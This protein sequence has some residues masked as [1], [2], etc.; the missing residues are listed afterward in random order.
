MN[1]KNKLKGR[2]QLKS[3]W[4]GRFAAV[5][6]RPGIR[7]CPLQGRKERSMFS[8]FIALPWVLVFFDSY[9]FFVDAG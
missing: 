3:V 4:F 8:I 6:C 5:V 7:L 1:G 2:K 9:H